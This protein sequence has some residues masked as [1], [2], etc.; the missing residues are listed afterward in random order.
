[1]KKT[2]ELGAA[3]ASDSKSSG[4]RRIVMKIRPLNDRILIK[5]LESKE[6]K[7]GETVIPD[8]GG[9][10]RDPFWASSS[11]PAAASASDSKKTDSGGMS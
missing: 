4:F 10:T 6:T 1:L 9:A 7:K 11:H 2:W 5:R 8:T 3:S